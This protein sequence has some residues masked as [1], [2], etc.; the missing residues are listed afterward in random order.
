ML[1]LQRIIANFSGVTRNDTMEDKS[2]LVVPMVMLTE[3]VHSGSEGPLYYPA[4]ELA[5][6]PQIWNHKPVIVYH[7][8]SSEPSACQ[9]HILSNRKI[10]VIMNT[11]FVDG[12]L[13]AEAWLEVDRANKVD[14]RVMESIQNKQMMELSTGL[15][16][17]TIKGE[18]VW[19]NEKYSATV[20][21]Y[22]PD[23]LA[24]L[25]DIKGACSIE[26]GAG[27]LRLNSA[28]DALMIDVSSLP[29]DEQTALL[30]NAGGIVERI[31]RQIIE[32]ANKEVSHGHIHTLIRAKLQSLKKEAWVEEVFNNFFIYEDVA[33]ASF[34]KQ[35]YVL[36][37][38]AIEFVGE[39]EKVV[40]S[41]EYKTETEMF[42]G[43]KKETVLRKDNDMDKKQLLDAL[44]A[45]ANT[46]WKEEDRAVL[47]AMEESVLNKLMP[48]VKEEKK[49]DAVAAKEEPKVAPVVENKETKKKDVSNMTVEQF[50]ANEVPAGLQ[51]VL[52]NGLKAYNAEKTGLI[53]I[54]LANEN[55]IFTDEQLQKKELEELICLASLAKS[56]VNNFVG[57]GDPLR[58]NAVKEEPL[59]LPSM[60]FNA[61]N[62]K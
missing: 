51:A 39:R 6:T 60:T 47:E 40:K 2:F 59:A 27:F 15:F 13:K 61:R 19:N 29:I 7:P 30:A 21:N 31:N 42:V 4:E 11:V 5:K 28:K 34:Y 25:P 38:D 54:V 32:Y 48:I 22:R 52:T 23:H 45:N 55:N 33:E 46:A 12:K 36:L 10:G 41:I 50:I 43:N 18:G 20:R 35:A 57:Q 37:K 1:T 9:P 44:I 53:Q 56:S 14:K 16:V 24:L 3:G 17:D 49:T 8:Q 26:D 62:K 58:T